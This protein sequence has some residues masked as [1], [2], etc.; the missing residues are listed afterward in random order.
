MTSPVLGPASGER[1]GPSHPDGLRRVN[2]GSGPKNFLPDWW[3][4]DVRPFAGIDQVMDATVAWPWNDRL[5]YV[6]GEHFLEHLTVSQAL[7]FLVEAGNALECG[8]RIRLSTPALEW[9]LKTHFSLLTR[10]PAEQ[11][12]QTWAIN[13]AFHGWG[14]QFLYSRETLLHFIAQTGFESPLIFEYGR[15]Y[16]PA[17]ENLERHSGWTIT[18]GFPSVWIIEAVRGE[19][20]I[21]FPE[22]LLGE[23]EEAY[24]VY[25][26][27][28]H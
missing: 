1:R 7:R 24:L 2:V 9:V 17:L 11:R 12:A 14:H 22:K 28:G 23:A 15:S 26:R 13:R 25:T 10:D 16:T 5:E 20:P 21:A 8:G 3:N 19:T 27:S 6:Y 18:G 4:V